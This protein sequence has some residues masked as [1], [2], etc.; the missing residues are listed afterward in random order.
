MKTKLILSSL[1]LASAL[2][3]CS[4]E[5]DSNGT[6]GNNPFNDGRTQV[7][8][9]ID[10]GNAMTRV[11]SDGESMGYDGTDK[12]GGV[13]VDSKTLWTVD[14]LHRGNNK[15]NWNGSKFTTEGTTSVGSWVFYAPYNTE[16]TTK[17]DGVE[18]DFLQI[19]EGAADF[20]EMAKVDF[21]TSPVIQLDGFE[22]EQLT[23]NVLTPSIHSRV[24]MQL[25]VPGGATVVQ[26]IVVKAKDVSDN[27]VK[28][29]TEGK[30]LSKQ[31][32]VANVC[33]T[34]SNANSDITSSLKTSEEV[35]LDAV[36]EMVNT[37]AEGTYSYVEDDFKAFSKD[38]SSN[39]T[40]KEYLV[41]DCTDHKTGNSMAIV[42]GQ[43]KAFMLM[44]AGNYKSVTLYAYTDKG[45]YEYVVNSSDMSV[46]M[47]TT[48]DFVLRRATKVNLAKIGGTYVADKYLNESTS[49]AYS[50]LIAETEGVVA[51]NTVDLV[52]VIKNIDADAATTVNVIS[53]G[54]AHRMVIDQSVATALAEVLTMKTNATLKFTGAPVYIKGNDSQ[55][56]PLVLEHMTF[57]EGCTVESGFVEIG[58]LIDIPVSK[59]IIVNAGANVDF[60]TAQSGGNIYNK[61]LLKGSVDVTGTGVE[62]K[63]ITNENGTLKIAS[64]LETETAV[65]NNGNIIIE[66]G[67]VWTV[68]D[69]TNAA[70][71]T[72]SA[73]Q[74][75]TL[76]NKGMVTFNGTSAN[77]ST[78]TNKNEMHV[79]EDATFTNA[80]TI[81]NEVGRFIADA[82]NLGT[83]GGTF[84]NTGTFINKAMLA[85][86][87][88]S[89]IAAE[90][91]KIVN[92]GTIQ[93]KTGAMTY[94]TENVISPTL[95]TITLDDRD[96]NMS[97]TTSAQQGTIEWTYNGDKLNKEL[98]DKF[99]KVVLTAESD[100]D[101]T[102]ITTTTD[103]SAKAVISIEVNGANNKKV[104]LPNEKTFKALTIKAGKNVSVYCSKTSIAELTIDEG[105]TLTV[106]TGQIFG[107]YK[108]ESATDISNAVA[109]ASISNSGTMVVGGNFWTTVTGASVAGNGLFLSGAGGAYHW[110][111]TVNTW[112]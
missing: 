8:L 34:G 104:I 69:F 66:E 90:N 33:I 41:L 46:E 37:D 63:T 86:V 30:I 42:N 40:T 24:A 36:Y 78:V 47:P 10:N 71:N 20:T 98:G 43:F 85:C 101:L 12:L 61:V 22:G 27:S 55:E 4:D 11:T 77:N 80:S 89:S 26:K 84:K 59:Q 32:P 109:D 23:M 111:A 94:I 73:L 65:T 74:A 31:L 67:A 112:E 18:Y 29:P 35:M 50:E 100:I 95:G 72:M 16:M 92:S 53:E 21:F 82:K 39:A 91:G 110:G 108:F 44:P 97:V 52:N 57:T 87:D 60:A 106:P 13:I 81:I 15:W 9:N 96:A 5:M 99:N 3:S 79:G 54:D 17:T 64:T 28:F 93:A 102:N 83:G 19:Q 76:V 1:V 107:A 7:Y 56:S 75:G 45:V 14:E 51:I 48:E 6:N 38:R 88:Q 2:V 105:A 68:T 49:K 62:I 25:Q 58:N 70:A 103:N